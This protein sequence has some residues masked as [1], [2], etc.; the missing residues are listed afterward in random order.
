MQK[1]TATK[2][3]LSAFALSFAAAVPTITHASGGSSSSSGGGNRGGTAA[4]PNPPAPSAGCEA[5]AAMSVSAGYYDVAAFL[6]AKVTVSSSCTR[7]ATFNVSYT[8][9]DSGL[10]DS[11]GSGWVAPGA[12]YTLAIRGASSYSTPYLVTLTTSDETGL[13]STQTTTIT[14]PPAP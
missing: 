14:T 13:V 3:L 1:L 10:V 12:T 8:N 2:V 4:A 6:R 7:N 11:S 5:I 9:L